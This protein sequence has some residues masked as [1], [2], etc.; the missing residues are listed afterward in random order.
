[1]ASSALPGTHWLSLR[2]KATGCIFGALST[3]PRWSFPRRC[4][5]SSEIAIVTD[6]LERI[7]RAYKGYKD[8]NA[9]DRWSLTNRGNR[10]ALRERERATYG[11]LR[12]QGWI[13]L[14]ARRV[15]E[16]G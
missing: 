15:L 13:P 10:A 5:R 7:E 3:H 6:E 12:A 2:R 8:N 16:V 14:G 4:T 1:M 11:L 9:A